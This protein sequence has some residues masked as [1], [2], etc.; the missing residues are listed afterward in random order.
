M[1]CYREKPW[2]LWQDPVLDTHTH[3][4]MTHHCTCICLHTHPSQPMLSETW[5]FWFNRTK[6][7][8]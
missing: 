8:L 3:V 4:H 1:H 7:P 2:E 5:F 6:V